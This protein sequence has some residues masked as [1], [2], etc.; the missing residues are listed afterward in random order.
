MS[1]L[2]TSDNP[3]E[4][5]AI[6]Q[7]QRDTVG[8]QGLEFGGQGTSF[9]RRKNERRMAE[10]PEAKVQEPDVVQEKPSEGKPTDTTAIVR[11]ESMSPLEKVRNESAERAG[12]PTSGQI[13]SNARAQGRINRQ[14]KR[15]SQRLNG[16][17]DFGSGRSTS[18]ANARAEGRRIG[19][20]ARAGRDGRA[21]GRDA[22]QGDPGGQRF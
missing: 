13:A 4:R 17:G 19:R 2:G 15:R 6:L 16:G 12:Q 3:N 1:G 5:A 7:N 14:Q 10:A 22:S 11:S 20:A 9:I 8:D 21:G 18:N